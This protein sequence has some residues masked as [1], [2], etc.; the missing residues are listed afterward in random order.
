MNKNFVSIKLLQLI[1]L[2]ITK[3]EMV[4]DQDN[5]SIINYR[6]NHLTYNNFNPI[7]NRDLARCLFKY[8]LNKL[9]YFSNTYCM[10]YYEEKNYDD[11]T[12]SIVARTTETTYISGYYHNPSLAYIDCLFKMSGINTNEL[13]SLD[14]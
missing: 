5:R 1:G 10:M 6:G 4:Q 12:V 3:D 9:E 14:I 8:F 7:D 11:H 2:T 13:K